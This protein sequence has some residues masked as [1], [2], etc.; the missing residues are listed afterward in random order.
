MGQ[1]GLLRLFVQFLVVDA[2]RFLA[3]PV[4]EELFQL[5]KE[6]EVLLRRAL[7]NPRLHVAGVGQQTVLAH[8]VDVADD[9]GLAHAEDVGQVVH[10]AFGLGATALGGGPRADKRLD[11][12][13]RLFARLLVKKWREHQLAARLVHGFYGNARCKNVRRIAAPLYEAGILKSRDGRLNA[14]FNVFH[15][16]APSGLPGNVQWRAAH[17]APFCRKV[18]DGL[19]HLLYLADAELG[20]VEQ[21]EMLVEVAVGV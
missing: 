16:V 3:K 12:A 4:Q 5:Q 1:A 18:L 6:V 21:D 20:L 19:P 2:Q 11:D 7:G 14:G 17:L 9:G 10:A 15:A 13:C 8:E